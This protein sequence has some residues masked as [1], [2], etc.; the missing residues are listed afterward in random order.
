MQAAELE[1]D[2]DPG[3]PRARA[4]R[5]I[6]MIAFS[7]IAI[8][9]TGAVYLHP[10]F[11]LLPSRAQPAAPLLHGDYRVVAVDFV[12]P[13]VGWL[14]VDFASGDFAVIHTA[15]AGPTGPSRCSSRIAAPGGSARSARGRTRTRPRTS[16]PRGRAFHC[17][18]SLRRHPRAAS[19]SSPCGRPRGLEPSPRWSTSRP[20]RAGQVSA[21]SSAGIRR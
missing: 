4:G 2:F 9:V 8:V 20:S 1:T 13:D 21:A 10:T 18:R 14:V 15:D 6:A 12:S 7:L 5:A 19:T 17:R 16:G 11:S 3:M